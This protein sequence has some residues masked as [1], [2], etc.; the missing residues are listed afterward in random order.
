MANTIEL[1]V[2]DLGGSHDVPVI[3]ILVKVGDT[4][5]KDQSLVTLESDK[6]TMDVP[7]SQAGRIVELKVKIGDELNDGSVIALIEAEG[8]EAPAV[9]KAVGQSTVKDAPAAATPSPAPAP[10]KPATPAT[11]AAATAGAGPVGLA[12]CAWS[13]SVSTLMSSDF[14][15]PNGHITALLRSEG[16]P[17]PDRCRGARPPARPRR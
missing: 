14:F 16:R 1:K 5:A 13:S 12:A 7:A 4:V 17:A 8:A 10:P 6:A 9:E 15:L 2:P 3:E 11:P